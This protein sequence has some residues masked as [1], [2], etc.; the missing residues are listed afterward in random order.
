MLPMIKDYLYILLGLVIYSIGYSCFILP[1]QITS[2][3]VSG[4]AALIFYGSG[5]NAAYS[6][7]IINIFLMVLALKTMGWRYCVRT[8]LAILVMSF[9]IDYAQT[10]L[11]DGNG[12]MI[13]I[14]GEQKFMACV[15][16]GCMDGIGMGFVF[17]GGGSTGGTDI[18]A[19][20]INKHHNISLG[21]ILLTMDILIVSCNWLV[22]HDMETLVVSY[23][24]MFI[25][26]NMLD[27]VINGARQSI[28]FLI[29]SERY[30]TIA[31]RINNELDRGVTVLDGR[32]WYSGERCHVLLVLAKKYE[33]RDIYRLIQ[34]EDPK[35][36][37]SMSNV[38]GVFGEGFE[39]IKK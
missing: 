19:S 38:E 17:L 2:G 6:F 9:M 18:I 31:T 37:V 3:G 24:T 11:Y 26:M 8:L 32:G 29:I 5:F 35:A 20:A 34:S 27:Y 12:H 7:L 16:G 36:F 13:H 30:E 15:L 22:I 14:V 28:Q 1:Y 4:I 39:K 21:R 23:S 33:R 10:L 25:A